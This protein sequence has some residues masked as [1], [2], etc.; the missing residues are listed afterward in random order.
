VT[1]PT[2]PEIRHEE[3]CPSVYDGQKPRVESYPYL[4][5][6]PVTGRTRATHTVHRCQDCGAATYIPRS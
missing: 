6:D 3:F 5:D 1:A 2:K 4:G